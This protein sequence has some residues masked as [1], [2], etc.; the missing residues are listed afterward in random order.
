M[1]MFS[2]QVLNQF[3]ELDYEVYNFILKNLSL[4]HI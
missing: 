2:N 3:S 4:I 1:I